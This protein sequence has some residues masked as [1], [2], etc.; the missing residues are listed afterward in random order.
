[1][2]FSLWLI[3]PTKEKK[4]KKTLFLTQRLH[5]KSPTKN[6]KCVIIVKYLCFCSHPWIV[7]LSKVCG[8]LSLE[9]Q[10]RKAAPEHA[11]PC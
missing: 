10:E 9:V 3:V 1:M 5:G 11:L 4:E 2:L 8:C 6:P 7:V